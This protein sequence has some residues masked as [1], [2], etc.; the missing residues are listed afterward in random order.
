M[1][2]VNTAGYNI[3]EYI[4]ELGSKAP[5]PGGGGASAVAGALSAALSSMVCNL[6][7]GKKSY[8]SVEDD[9]KKILEDM[10]K[11][12]ESFI[13]LSDKDAEVFYPLSQAYGFKPQNDEEKKMHEENMEKLLFDAAMVPLDIMKEAYSMLVA[14]DFLAKKG[15]K[16]AVSDAGVA[17]SMLRSAVC[18]AMMNV[19][20]NVKYMKN[21]EK[22]QDLMDEAS[23]ILENTMNKAD[24]IYREVLEVLL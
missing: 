8:I 23:E 24:I 22:A 13:K 14:V 5:V 7:V 12:M 3:D 17:V 4:K 21:R 15:S 1:V 11:H 16:L 19:V 2:I 20:I 9:I 18:G 6:T 10:N